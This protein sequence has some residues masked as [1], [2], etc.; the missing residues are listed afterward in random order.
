MFGG[1]VIWGGM[2][3]CLANVGM[4]GRNFTLKALKLWGEGSC[5]TATG[6]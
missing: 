4:A 2:F 1:E 3:V 5:V 6:G